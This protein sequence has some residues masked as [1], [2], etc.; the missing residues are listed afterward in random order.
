MSD[1]AHGHEHRSNVLIAD[2]SPFLARQLS[3]DSRYFEVLWP[4]II[5]QCGWE[6]INTLKYVSAYFRR[7]CKFAAEKLESDSVRVNY[8]Q[9]RE[10]AFAM[11]KK[12]QP[13]RGYVA[14]GLPEL[15]LK[16]SSS[17]LWYSWGAGNCGFKSAELFGRFLELAGVDR[18]SVICWRRPSRDSGTY[19]FRRVP[20]EELQ[21][22]Q[23]T[24]RDWHSVTRQ[25]GNDNVYH[26]ISRDRHLYFTADNALSADNDEYIYTLSF[27]VTGEKEKALKLEQFFKEECEWDEFIRGYREFM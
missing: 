19:S 26:W 7:L 1:A 2:F 9:V 21:H 27:G 10:Y 18:E 12:E 6:E 24:P 20:Y 8:W 13:T 14:M 5:E 11:I 17:L 25:G 16:I 15:E 3:A 22:E 23:S 4:Y